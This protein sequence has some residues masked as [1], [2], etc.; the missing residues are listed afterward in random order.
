MA[1]VLFPLFVLEL[2]RE[3]HPTDELEFDETEDK[4]MSKFYVE[5]GETKRVLMAKDVKEACVLFLKESKEKDQEIS[6]FISVSEMGYIDE[7]TGAK[8]TNTIV[9]PLHMILMMLM[10]EGLDNIEKPPDLNDTD[11]PYDPDDD[12]D[13]NEKYADGE[14]WKHGGDILEDPGG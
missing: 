6:S 2:F 13:P 5:S 9:I 11:T 4:K 14:Q 1:L 7:E 3:Y 12:V 8:Q 10:F